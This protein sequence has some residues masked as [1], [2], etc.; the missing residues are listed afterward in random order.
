MKNGPGANHHLLMEIGTIFSISLL[1]WRRMEGWEWQAVCKFPDIMP[2]NIPMMFLMILKPLEAVLIKE[3]RLILIVFVDVDGRVA[4]VGVCE[5]GEGNHEGGES[6]HG[7]S[8]GVGGYM[9]S[10]FCG[11][12]FL[13]DERR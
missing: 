7:G 1:K 6:G 11:E 2:S 8:T 9:T 5:E 10:L 12:G 13:L 4:E 3:L